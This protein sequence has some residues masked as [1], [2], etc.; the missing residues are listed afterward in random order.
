MV[1]AADP[2][3]RNFGFLDREKVFLIFTKF[4]F[5]RRLLTACVRVYEVQPH[6]F[7]SSECLYI[8]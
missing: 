4:G 7:V 2:Y 6:L 3:G 8:L 1:S 5:G